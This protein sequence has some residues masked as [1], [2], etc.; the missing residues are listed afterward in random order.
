[1]IYYLLPRHFYDGNGDGIG[2][3]Q[4]VIAKLDYLRDLGVTAIA[5]GETVTLTAT[6]DLAVLPDLGTLDD[7]HTLLTEAH[8]RNLRLLL[9][10]TLTR[11]T[12]S[13]DRLAQTLASGV[14]STSGFADGWLCRDA[15]R[16]PHSLWKAV[17]AAV[18]AQNPE[19]LLLAEVWTQDQEQLSAYFAD[20]FD[21][22]L[23]TPLY[24]A[25]MG[26]PDGAIWGAFSG[27][28]PATRIMDIWRSSIALNPVGAQN[29]VFASSDVTPRVATQAGGDARR[30]RQIAAL[31]LTLGGP[32]LLTYGEEIGLPGPG[33]TG[34]QPLEVMDWYASGRGPGMV[35]QVP[36]TGH[37][38][39]G[40]SVEEQQEQPDSLLAYYKNL[41]SFRQA[42]GA[43][44]SPRIEPVAVTGADN[45]LA[46]VKWD[47]LSQW[48]VIISFH[49]QPVRATLNL[50]G[51]TLPPGAYSVFDLIHGLGGP[52]LFRNA[53]YI[54][55]LPAF[56][57]YVLRLDATGPS[58]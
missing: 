1:V 6:G 8:K 43:L 26:S 19:A 29:V 4:G 40:I 32:A 36:S 20:E 22:V 42:N 15:T 30:L 27:K 23:D 7:L 53:P 28:A 41:L 11:A 12:P 56:A 51:T 31:L 16:M 18:K 9:G 10:I 14:H 3:I 54:L 2:D 13:P 44:R 45:I 35:T 55:D 5:L 39:D 58:G 50:T 47:P 37:P 38:Y 34:A 46:Y 52:K 57:A 33:P 25:L 21:A 17:R 48:L 24:T 49:D